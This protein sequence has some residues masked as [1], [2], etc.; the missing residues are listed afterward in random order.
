MSLRRR[1]ARKA[2][3][4]QIQTEE[5][6]VMIA[7]P[8]QDTVLAT[9]TRSVVQCVAYSIGQGLRVGFHLAQYSILPLS[10]QMLVQVA[11]ESGAT[12]VLFIDSDMEFPADLAVRLVRH[13]Q[14][15]VAVNCM[16]RRSPYYLT[17]RDEAGREVPTNTESSG[18]EKVA[19]VGTGIMLIHTDV[20][21]AIPMPWFQ[22][23]WI[24]EKA[25][26]RGE[27]FYFCDKARAA[28]FDLYIDH[29]LSK[30]VSHVGT[31][32]FNPLMKAGFDEVA[33]IANR[34]PF[35]GGAKGEH[36]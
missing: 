15:I 23:E 16:A 20:V 22:T 8:A 4:L 19:R 9:Y 17:A 35:Q 11:I 31:F 5:P 12:H 25:V 1:L 26:F 29:D 7:T 10:R 18:L 32:Q 27:D 36:A 14:P 30:Q 2:H 33:E 28:G 21:R 13:R 24:P 34:V 3:R 6:V